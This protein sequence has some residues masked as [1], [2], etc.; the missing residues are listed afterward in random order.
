MRKSI[1]A[2]AT[3]AATSIA[4]GAAAQ[5]YIAYTTI[6]GGESASITFVN[7]AFYGGDLTYSITGNGLLRVQQPPVP[8][9]VRVRYPD[10]TGYTT[11]TTL[12]TANA[13]RSNTDPGTRY[14]CLF[15]GRNRFAI[16][17]EPLCANYAEGDTSVTPN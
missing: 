11:T 17:I 14:W 7:S 8:L 12:S 4:G 3:L 16:N 15:V 6:D 2:L 13:V 9:V 10:G 5:Q 1:L